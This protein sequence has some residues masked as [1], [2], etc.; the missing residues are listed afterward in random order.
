M[1]R[2]GLERF[3]R[4]RQRHEICAT[5]EEA[6]I[7]ISTGEVSELSRRFVHYLARLHQARAERLKAALESDG[8]WPMHVDATGEGGRGTLLLEMAGWRQWV[9]GAW[10]ISTERAELI[11]PCLR[12]TVRRFGAPCA[13]MRDLGRA[14]TPAID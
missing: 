5:I 9:L 14:M 8:G 12:E 4:H 13:V 2:V 11:L 10:K 3:V 7:R 1:V 6:G